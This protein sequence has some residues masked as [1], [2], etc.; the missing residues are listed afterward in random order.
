MLIFFFPISGDFCA[1]L[2]FFCL[3]LFVAKAQTRQKTE[4]QKGKLECVTLIRPHLTPKTHNNK[5]H[6]AHPLPLE[7]RNQQ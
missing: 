2:A 7:N 3:F 1:K 4:Q 6:P 5:P